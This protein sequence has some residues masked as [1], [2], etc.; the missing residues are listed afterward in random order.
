[1]K[2][3]C[4]ILRQWLCVCVNERLAVY[5]MA[6]LL[7]TSQSKA[8]QRVCWCDIQNVVVVQRP[9]FALHTRS[10]CVC[11]TH[12]SDLPDYRI[13]TEMVHQDYRLHIQYRST[14]WFCLSCNF[15]IFIEYLLYFAIIEQSI[16]Q[17][18]NYWP[19]YIM[20]FELML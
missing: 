5:Y 15:I 6:C 9:K 16:M 14:V 17:V 12:R 1:M 19:L 18:L 7:S 10:E 4:C 11:A 8:R 3:V 13:Q 20:G 2:Y